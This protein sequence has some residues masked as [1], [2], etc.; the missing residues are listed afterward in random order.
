MKLK[1]TYLLKNAVFLTVMAI[2]PHSICYWLLLSSIGM[3]VFK[4]SFKFSDYFFGATSGMGEVALRHSKRL[5]PSFKAFSQD[6]I[7]SK[8]DQSVLPHFSLNSQFNDFLMTSVIVSISLYYA[9]PLIIPTIIILFAAYVK[10]PDVKEVVNVKP[11]NKHTRDFTR[12]VGSPS[13]EEPRQEP[14]HT[15][16]RY[17]FTPGRKGREEKAAFD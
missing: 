12:Q 8:Y 1:H 16:N 17:P 11:A 6:L 2:F 15:T 4:F 13:S 14:A 5:V 3:D 7:E 10:N 9:V